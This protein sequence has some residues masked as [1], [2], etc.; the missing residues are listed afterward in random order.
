MHGIKE[1][2][3]VHANTI[4]TVI[5]DIKENLKF[6]II[7]TNPPFEEEESDNTKRKLPASYQ[8]RDTALGFLLQSMRQICRMSMVIT[9]YNIYR[10]LSHYLAKISFFSYYQMKNAATIMIVIF[11][12]LVIVKSLTISNYG[13]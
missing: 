13:K 9:A 3:I 2:N 10:Y 4:E 5:Q 8:T 6:D 12:R 11:Q 7:M 1:P